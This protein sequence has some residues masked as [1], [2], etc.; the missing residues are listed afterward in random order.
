[1]Q[2]YHVAT[3]I[4]WPAEPVWIPWWRLEEIHVL[5]G[6]QTTVSGPWPAIALAWWWWWWYNDEGGG[7][8]ETISIFENYL[9]VKMMK[10]KFLVALHIKVTH[11]GEWRRAV[12]PILCGAVNCGAGSILRGKAKRRQ[13]M[14][15]SMLPEGRL[16]NAKGFLDSFAKI[17]K[18]DY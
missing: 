9:A 16:S 13:G 4:Q 10:F 7:A 1:M 15:L 8:G 14:D 6:N 2:R 18:S 3:A 17:A 12:W 5:A 11:Y